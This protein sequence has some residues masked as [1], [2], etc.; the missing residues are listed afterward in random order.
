M[1]HT[2][3]DMLSRVELMADGDS[4][5]WDLS[6]NDT[7]ALA[8]VLKALSTARG[9]CQ[10]KDAKLAEQAQEIE[11][12][13][14]LVSDIDGGFDKQC[15]AR[16]KAERELAEARE[17]AAQLL[18]QACSIRETEDSPWVIDDFCISAYEDAVDYFRALG[19]LDR[20]P[21]GQDRYTWSA[22]VRAAGGAKE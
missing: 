13:N 9:D 10:R 5:T 16:E 19:W 4:G 12:L 18:S 11:R 7:E 20:L 14:K 21:S 6:P 2:P 17:L 8:W 15:A 1:S 22:A 3:E